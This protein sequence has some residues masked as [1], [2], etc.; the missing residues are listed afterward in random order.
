M[1]IW[2][3]SERIPQALNELRAI[4]LWGRSTLTHAVLSGNEL[5]FDAALGA[6]RSEVEDEEVGISPMS[7]S[8]CVVLATADT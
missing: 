2:L 7:Y 8:A 5:L 6:I 3:S 4:D 1:V